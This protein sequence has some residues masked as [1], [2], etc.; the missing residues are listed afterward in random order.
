MSFRRPLVLWKFTMPECPEVETVARSLS[1][2]IS[3]CLFERASLLRSSALHPLSLPLETLIGRSA[4]AVRRRGKLLIFDLFPGS[5]GED[6]DR[7]P[8]SLL[9]HLRMTGRMLVRDAGA[10]PGKHTRC[11]WS[12]RKPDA[13]P[14]QLF[15]DD[16][17]TFGKVFAANQEILE[18]WD[19]W[20]NLGPEPLELSRE[21]FIPLLRGQRPIK[22]CLL[23]QSVV[24][25]IGNIYA[26]ESLF[27]AGIDPARPADS[28]SAEEGGR[29]LDSIQEIL[30]WAIE[31]K[32]S[33]I[34]DY[35]DA[36]GNKGSFQNNFSVY[37]RAGKTCFKCGGEL[38][39]L[40]INGRSTVHCPVCQ[41]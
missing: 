33:S 41:K 36:D 11:V 22:S 3:G 30:K 10:A 34:R 20:R 39:K 27:R 12:M 21:A 37:G 28:L 38:Q 13:S 19:F 24:A 18:K 7:T 23:D 14:F 16:A 32:G 5:G 40:K 2:H 8:D 17:R 29:L 25:G 9:V 6:S 26:D 35:L 15:F 4:R 31:N 1:A